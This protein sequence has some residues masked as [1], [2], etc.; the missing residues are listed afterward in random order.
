MNFGALF[1]GIELLVMLRR[2][3]KPRE[4]L[5]DLFGWLA[6]T[7]NHLVALR[8]SCFVLVITCIW[9]FGFATRLAGTS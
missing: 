6:Y 9:F 4:K 8:N 5:S 7:R 1:L 3:L 2:M